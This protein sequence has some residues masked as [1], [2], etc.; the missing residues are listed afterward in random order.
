[1]TTSDGAKELCW[2]QAPP[3]SRLRTTFGDR[4]WSPLEP[5]LTRPALIAPDGL[6]YTRLRC[7]SAKN[8]LSSLSRQGRARG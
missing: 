6:P 3:V 8:C 2:L 7:L 1:M 5:V 4:I